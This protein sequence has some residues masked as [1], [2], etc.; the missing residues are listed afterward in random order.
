MTTRRSGQRKGLTYSQAGVSIAEGDAL[1]ARL[2][3][4][5]KAIGG[6]SGL[7]DLNVRGMREPVLLASTDGVG[8]KLL[9]A[10]KLG[11]LDT[12]GIDLVAMVVND[13]IVTG[14]RPL[15]FLDY[16]AT[17]KLTRA[18]SDAVLAG[19]MAGCREADVPLLGGETA[20]MPGLYKPGDFDLA[21]FGV[22]VADRRRLVDGST[23]QPG[24]VVIG[25]G[26][27]GVHSNGFSL[28][29]AIVKRARRSMGRR[30]EGLDATLGEAL[31]RPTVIYVRAV[32]ALLEAARPTA[33]AHITGGGLPGNVVR[34]LPKDA[35]AVIDTS[36][37]P[38]PP[39][40]ARLQEWGDVDRDEMFRVFNMG[41]G[42]VVVCRP[43]DATR[44]LKA[45]EASGLPAW[46]I[47][48]ILRGRRGVSLK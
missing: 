33:M 42:Y 1:V 8:T 43:G 13:L 26:S 29:R 20:E 48:E 16:Y 37:W 14:A 10:Q 17:G 6:F 7:F 31:L 41:I 2:A 45:L 38:L 24:D 9:V 23:V 5:N 44:C 34:V 18:E 22:A 21:G 28:V 12:V 35:R 4:N 30:Y 47:G 40:F 3:K 25:V 36:A 15:F 32:R 39:L 11:K 19:V 27:S 46:R